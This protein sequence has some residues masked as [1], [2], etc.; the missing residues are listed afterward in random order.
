MKSR[1]LLYTASILGLLPLH[2][3]QTAQN[4]MPQPCL[5]GSYLKLRA[6]PIGASATIAVGQG[7]AM[8]S[9][10]L[11]DATAVKSWTWTSADSAIAT[12]TP[13]GVVTGIKPG[14]FSLKATKGNQTLKAEGFIMPKDW[15]VEFEPPAA[16]VKVGES[17]KL[18]VIAYDTNH[19]K[20]P[21]VPFSVYTPEFSRQENEPLVSPWSQQQATDTAIFRASKPGVTQMIGKIADKQVEMQLTITP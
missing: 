6:L 10:C 21:P 8:G 9:D 18:K 11:D 14:T 4:A 13:T 1:H 16:T 3:C 20:L 12:V 7:Q 15:T 19:Q 2:A 5:Q 17:V